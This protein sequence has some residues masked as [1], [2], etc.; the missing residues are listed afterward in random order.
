MRN[1]GLKLYQANRIK[2]AELTPLPGW[3]YL[4]GSSGLERLCQSGTLGL[5]LD[6]NCSFVTEVACADAWFLFL[7]S[8]VPEKKN[9]RSWGSQH[10]RLEVRGARRQN[11]KLAWE[12]AW[13][14]ARIKLSVKWLSHRS[15]RP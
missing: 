11:L 13:N 4:N 6:T 8:V 12:D 1:N 7:G 9:W 3:Q 2:Q 15:V 5:A 10:P 14:H